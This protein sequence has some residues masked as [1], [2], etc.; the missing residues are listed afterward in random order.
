MKNII[1]LILLLSIYS[2]ESIEEQISYAHPQEEISLFSKWPGNFKPSTQESSAWTNHT[3]LAGISK[4][5][6]FKWRLREWIYGTE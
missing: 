1:L 3:P 6:I 4:W 2:C 5:D